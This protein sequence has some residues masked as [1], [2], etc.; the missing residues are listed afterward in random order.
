[1]D[2]KTI[3]K[4]STLVSGIVAV[5]IFSARYYLRNM[6]FRTRAI[7]AIR[8]REQLIAWVLEHAH[9]TNQEFLFGFLEQLEFVNMITEEY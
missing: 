9:E 2:S 5:P 3:F 4:Y 1:M 6:Y 8:V 7:E